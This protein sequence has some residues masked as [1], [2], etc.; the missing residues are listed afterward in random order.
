M[1]E[2]CGLLKISAKTIQ[3]LLESKKKKVI[4]FHLIEFSYNLFLILEKKN[5]EFSFRVKYVFYF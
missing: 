2:K 4:Y 3:I 1:K 5:I